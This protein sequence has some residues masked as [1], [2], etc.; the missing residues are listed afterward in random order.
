MMTYQPTNTVIPE[1]QTM[2]IEPYIYTEVLESED[3]KIQ[4]IS[5]CS[6]DRRCS[7]KQIFRY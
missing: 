7:A 4:E 2:Q 1:R 5:E 3:R 6:R